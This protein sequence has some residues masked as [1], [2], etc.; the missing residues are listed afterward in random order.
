MIDVM[1]KNGKI[2]N[3]RLTLTNRK[4]A[5]IRIAQEHIV[6]VYG[7]DA[8]KNAAY[9]DIAGQSVI[10]FAAINGKS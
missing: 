10:Y 1:L 2:A 6:T 7:K 8:L 4:P 3:K 5:T 9:Y